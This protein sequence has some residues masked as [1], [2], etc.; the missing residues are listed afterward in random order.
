MSYLKWML[1]LIVTIE[2]ILGVAVSTFL[3]I[4]SLNGKLISIITFIISLLVLWY[5]NYLDKAYE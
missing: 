5:L 3:F 1:K 4:I 2:F